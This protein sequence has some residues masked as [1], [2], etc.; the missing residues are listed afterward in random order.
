MI[1]NDHVRFGPGAA[2]KGP[3]P[4]HLASGL[5]E[6]RLAR[7]DLIRRVPAANRYVLTRDGLL[8]AHIYTKIYDHVLRPL[9]TPD[10][11]NAPAELQAAI[12]TLDRLAADHLAR[13]RVPTA[14]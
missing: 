14:A 8:F 1:G 13:A 9:M 11:P 3:A 12:D 2:G 6:P 7:N 4:G 10:R 5:P